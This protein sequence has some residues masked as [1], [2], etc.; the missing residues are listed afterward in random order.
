MQTQADA[1]KT[2]T[3]LL[4]VH[5]VKEKALLMEGEK[6]SVHKTPNPNLHGRG[7]HGRMSKSQNSETLLRGMW[8]PWK[9]EKDAIHRSMGKQQIW[10]LVALCRWSRNQW[11]GARDQLAAS[12]NQLLMSWTVTDVRP[13]LEPREPAPST[14]RTK[15]KLHTQNRASK[16]EPDILFAKSTYGSLS[17]HVYYYIWKSPQ[18]SCCSCFCCIY[19]PHPKG[20]SLSD[21]KHKEPNLAIQAFPGLISK[22]LGHRGNLVSSSGF[23]PFLPFL[24]GSCLIFC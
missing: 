12:L 8:R 4:G 21:I 17:K 9:W 22:I 20:R 23:P 6:N 10:V 18:F 3:L 1:L 16:P 2:K 15:D 13:P 7:S 11:A 24:L 19:L 14:G 5:R